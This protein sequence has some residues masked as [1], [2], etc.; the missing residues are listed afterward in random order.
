MDGL[1]RGP[2]RE[3]PGADNATVRRIHGH[4]APADHNP[5]RARG[6]GKE[7]FLANLNFLDAVAAISISRRCNDRV[8]GLTMRRTKLQKRREASSSSCESALVNGAQCGRCSRQDTRPPA[9]KRR[10]N[11]RRLSHR[12]FKWRRQPPPCLAMEGPRCPRPAKSGLGRRGRRSGGRGPGL[13]KRCGSRGRPLG[14]QGRSA[15][16]SPPASRSAFERSPGQESSCRPGEGQSE[17]R[18]GLHLVHGPTPPAIF[19]QSSMQILHEVL[20][21]QGSGRGLHSLHRPQAS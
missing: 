18:R 16:P 8:R 5:N 12:P 7:W 10:L 6:A 17:Q 4:L 13:R 9:I 14:R 19:V 20:D 2:G 1:L 3:H 11:A 21:M 15:A